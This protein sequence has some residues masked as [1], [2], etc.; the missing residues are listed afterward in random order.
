M[1]ASGE[2]ISRKDAKAEWHDI[3]GKTLK[4]EDFKKL[5]DDED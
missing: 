3:L 5:A 1:R 4:G 2:V